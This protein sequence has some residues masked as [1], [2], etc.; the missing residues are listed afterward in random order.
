MLVWS[1]FSRFH[2]NGFQVAGLSFQDPA[3]L[4]AQ[5]FRGFCK[6]MVAPTEFESVSP[7]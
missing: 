1:A 6:K 3:R 7:P 4:E 5:G 2:R